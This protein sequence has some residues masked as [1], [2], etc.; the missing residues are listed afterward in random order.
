MA[1][2]PNTIVKLCS[3]PFDRSQ[4]NQVRFTTTALQTAY[5]ASVVTH[6]YTDFTYQ[7]KDSVIKVPAHIDSLWDSNY[8][9]YNNLHFT[10]QYFY[11]FIIRM[12]YISDTVTAIYIETDVYQTWFLAKATLQSSFVLREMQGT[13]TGGENTIDE[14]LEI[15]DIILNGTNAFCGMGDMDI[16]IATTQSISDGSPAAGDMYNGVYTGC[17]LYGVHPVLSGGVYT[18]LDE[19]TDAIQLAGQDTAIMSIFM[20]PHLISGCGTTLEWLQSDDISNNINISS[21][22]RPTAIDGYTP[23]NKKLLCFPYNYLTVHNN[24]GN[25]AIFKYERHSGNDPDFTIFGGVGPNSTYKIIPTDTGPTESNPD[26]EQ[27]L[28]LAGFPVCAW[29]TNVYSNW[30]AQNSGSVIIGLAGGGVTLAAGLTS[31]NPMVLAGGALA[32]GSSLASISQKKLE[33]P[34]SA[35]AINSSNANCS[36]AWNDFILAPKSITA[37]YAAIIDGYFDMYGYKQNLV[38]VPNVSSRTYWNYVK[39]A[40]CNITGD[41]PAEDMEKLKKIFNDG[42]TFWHAAANVGNYALNN[43]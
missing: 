16:I 5:F 26:Y 10:N 35:G 40:D 2:T 31:M 28:T 30:I 18:N 29:N 42:V 36:N 20:C 37:E 39:T 19:I 11:A 22:G 23:K 21:N 12:E 32:V 13:D 27:G 8:V 3:V 4:S 1:Y 6:S 34:Q 41:I 7:R 24:A 38:K 17:W 15:G 25:S 33:P 43:H 9:M 14:G